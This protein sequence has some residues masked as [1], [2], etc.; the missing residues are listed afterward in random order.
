MF[1]V[2]ADGEASLVTITIITP[3]KFFPNPNGSDDLYVLSNSVSSNFLPEPN[4]PRLLIHCSTI[5]LAV[6]LSTVVSSA[7][8]NLVHALSTYSEI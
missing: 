7:E 4:D 8:L 3:F 1:F 5:F 6:S 2:H